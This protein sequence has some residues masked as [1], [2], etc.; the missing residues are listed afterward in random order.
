MSEVRVP[1]D[2]VQALKSDAYIY[3]YF[4]NLPPSHRREYVNWIEE[5]KKPETLAARVKKTVLMVR[6]KHDLGVKHA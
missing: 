2:L 4:V 5:A 3:D 6:E 1:E